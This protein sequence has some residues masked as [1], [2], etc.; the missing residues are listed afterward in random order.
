MMEFGVME[1]GSSILD[2]GEGSDKIAR[3]SKTPGHRF[4]EAT[5]PGRGRIQ[6]PHPETIT[7]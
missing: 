3:A 5:T 1:N 2:P 6:S 4:H 7:T